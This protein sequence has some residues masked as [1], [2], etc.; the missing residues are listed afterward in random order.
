MGEGWG[1]GLFV[2]QELFVIKQKVPF[3]V[4]DILDAG[5]CDDGIVTF[6]PLVLVLPDEG[7]VMTTL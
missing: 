7:G 6:E 2:L 1:G 3:T 5:L 4:Q